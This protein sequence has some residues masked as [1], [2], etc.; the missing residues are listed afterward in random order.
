MKAAGKGGRGHDQD[1]EWERQLPFKIPA[2]KI[3]IT[4]PSEGTIRTNYFLTGNVP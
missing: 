1:R 4:H 3:E 2:S